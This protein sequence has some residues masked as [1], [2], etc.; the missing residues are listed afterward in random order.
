MGGTQAE[1]DRREQAIIRQRAQP[2]PHFGS[3]PCKADAPLQ[4]G[5]LDFSDGLRLVLRSHQGW[6]R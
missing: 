6:Q 5:R 1:F 4:A 2:V 3:A